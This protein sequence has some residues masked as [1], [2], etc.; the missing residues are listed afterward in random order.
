[1]V[2]VGLTLLLVV[3]AAAAVAGI[4]PM[5]VGKSM[6]DVVVV[7]RCTVAAADSNILLGNSTV[8]A[9]DSNIL[10]VVAE[11]TGTMVGVATTFSP[12]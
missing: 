2:I 1:M 10:V 3:V 9:A 12:G 4:N 8:A 5:V 11:G 6:V 7:G